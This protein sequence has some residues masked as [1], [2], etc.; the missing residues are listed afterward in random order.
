MADCLPLSGPSLSLSVDV[1]IAGVSG[2]L[3]G[4]RRDQSCGSK[5]VYACVFTVITG[6]PDRPSLW[7]AT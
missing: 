7:S 1:L 5:G 4:G 6:M 3:C 2:A